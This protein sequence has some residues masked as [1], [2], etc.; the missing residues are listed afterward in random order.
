MRTRRQPIPALPTVA[1][2]APAATPSIDDDG[3]RYRRLFEHAPEGLMRTSAAGRVLAVNPAMVRLL[4]LR[5]AAEVMA[6]YTD[7]AT[8]LYVDPARRGE[9]IRRL[10]AGELVDQFEAEFFRA[11]GRRGWMS[12]SAWAERDASGAVVE[13]EA[14]VRDVTGQK[15]AEADLVRTA[16]EARKLALVVSRTHIPVVVTDAAG[17]VEWV[18]DAFTALTGY[19]AGDL[20]GRRAAEVLGGGRTDATIADLMDR[21]VREGEP[22]EVELLQYGRGGRSFWL[23][24]DGEPVRDEAGTIRQWVAVMHDVT[25]RKRAGWLDQDRRHLL[26]RVA[27]H[28]PLEATLGAVCEAVVR[29]WDGVRAMILRC[30]TANDGSPRRWAAA[31]ER[32]SVELRAAV[33][34]SLAGA[35]GSAGP[36]A[37]GDAAAPAEVYVPDVSVSP[38]WAGELAVAAAADGVVACRSV[39]IVGGDGSLLGELLA[40]M[41]AEAVAAAS[42]EPFRRAVASFAGLAALAIEHQRLTDRLATQATHDPLTGLGNRAR[43]DASLPGWLAAAARA[44][45]PLGVLMIDLDGFKHVNDTLG[46]AAGDALLVQVA[47]RLSAAARDGDV[48]CR[49]GGD[50]FTLVATDLAEPRDVAR[51][52]GRLIAALSA[53]FAVDGRELFVTASVGTAAFP[54]DGSDAGALLRNADAAM[55]A[56][57]AA[58]RN[59]SAGFDPSMNAAARE[60]LDLEGRLRHLAAAITRTGGPGPELALAYQPQVD[61]AGRLRGIEALLRWACPRAGRVSPGKFIPV[62]EASG[63]IVPIGTWV[64]R[65]ACRQAAAWAA[66]GHRPVPIGVNVSAVQFA[67]GDFVAVVTA[68]LV[69]HELD[70]RWLEL[71]LTESVLMGTAAAAA[72][73][74]AA[75]RRLGVGTAIDDFGTG[76]SSLAYL[77]RLPIDQ[78]K[79]D[80]SFVRDLTA[81]GTAT[82]GVDTAVIT[83][84]VGLAANLGMSTV[85][86]GV[87]TVAQR[88]QVV[89]LGCDRLQGYLYSPPVSAGQMTAMLRRGRIGPAAAAAA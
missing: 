70:P 46:H 47:R 36:F 29:Q 31:V 65:E 76:Y 39:P 85:A 35:T 5:T 51:V 40:L 72:D 8:Q 6:W 56:A 22:F 81:A 80:Q 48:L 20:L 41:G 38:R 87:E 15:R 2:T 37:P 66:A 1:G 9:L 69:E 63:L 73:T 79:I 67:Q 50:E 30:D 82:S 59:R 4:G 13:I 3:R 89:A 44:N 77:R 78:L 54:A 58:G 28:E 7:L 19:A 14:T 34:W 62:A 84:V 11:D 68:A 26:E 52:A 42:D 83:A 16:A 25:D 33:D 24:V 27:R 45:R 53:P 64:L 60:R 43:L 49:M 61:P 32:V 88:D 18:N 86:E 10:R 55:Y 12:L 23:S 71:E 17:R 75:I 74:L 57:K 21:R